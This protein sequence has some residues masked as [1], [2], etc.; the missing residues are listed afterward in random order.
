MGKEAIME[1]R[2]SVE[3]EFAEAIKAINGVR[4]ELH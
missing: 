4:V 1:M 2:F 3:D